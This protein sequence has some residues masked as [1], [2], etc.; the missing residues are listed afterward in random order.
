[1]QSYAQT[2]NKLVLIFVLGKIK[3]KMQ[4]IQE[5]EEEK[6][7]FNITPASGATYNT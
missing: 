4:S 7:V 6:T 3:L 5:E 2:R 1:M